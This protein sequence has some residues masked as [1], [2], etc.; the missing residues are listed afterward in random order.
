[1][2]VARR[3]PYYLVIALYF[4]AIVSWG[5]WRN[6]FA[7]LLAGHADR[8]WIVHLH[9]AVFV[10]W[11][12]L[13]IAQTALAASGLVQLHRRVGRVGIAYGACVFVMGVAVSIGGPA[14]RVRAAEFPIEVGGMVALYSLADLLLFGAFLTLAF[15]YRAR[16]AVHKQWMIAA[17]AALGGAAVGRVLDTNSIPYLLVWLSPIFAVIA[18]DLLNR[19]RVSIVPILSGSLIVV[20]F[21]KVPLLA[22]SVW[23]DLGRALLTPFV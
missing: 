6:Y 16:S 10:G 1:M 13:L 18:I 19:R 21:F 11:V 3:R 14:L 8:P 4:A 23:Q 9:A 5:F 2:T 17:T 15:I 22:A 20:A 12:L 7:P